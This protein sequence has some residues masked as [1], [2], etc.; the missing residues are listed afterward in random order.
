MNTRR[1][2]QQIWNCIMDTQGVPCDFVFNSLMGKY[3]PEIIDKE[4]IRIWI[5]HGASF[6]HLSES[7]QK[8]RIMMVLNN[9]LYEMNQD[10]HALCAILVLAKLPQRYHD[11]FRSVYKDYLPR[12]KQ[13]NTDKRDYTLRL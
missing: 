9:L 10:A 8:L 13:P 1:E 3:L 6:Y 11:I 2:L 12:T 5:N 4:G 7:S